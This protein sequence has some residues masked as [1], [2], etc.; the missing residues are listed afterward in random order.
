MGA[1][2]VL[3]VLKIARAGGEWILRTFKTSRVTINHEMH[4]QVYTIFIIFHS[5]QNNCITCIVSLAIFQLHS[6]TCMLFMRS[7]LTNRKRV[8]LLSIY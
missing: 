2:V 7:S 8:I 3:K 1:I 6:I 4:E 5:R